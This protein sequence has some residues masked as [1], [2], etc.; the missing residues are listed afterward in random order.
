MIRASESMTDACM[1]Q[2]NNA[3]SPLV[4][5]LALLLFPLGVLALIGTFFLWR[6]G[7][8]GLPTLLSSLAGIFLLFYLGAYMIYSA[9]KRSQNLPERMNRLTESYEV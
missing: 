6:A 3:S 5:A 2:T 8:I 7:D 4:R 9:R 1:S